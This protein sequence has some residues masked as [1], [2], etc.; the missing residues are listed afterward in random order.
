MNLCLS[1]HGNVVRFESPAGIQQI[2]GGEEGYILCDATTGTVYHDTGTVEDGFGPPT[3]IQPNGV[4]SFPFT[5]VRTTLDGQFTL[6]QTFTRA[7]PRTVGDNELRIQS[8][9]ANNT[10]TSHQLQLTRYVNADADGSPAHDIFG[11]T[12]DAVLAW[13]SASEVG[14]SG[15]G[16][17]MTSLAYKAGTRPQAAV[18]EYPGTRTACGASSLVTPRHG[19]NLVGELTHG[20]LVGPMGKGKKGSDH[21]TTFIVYS[22]F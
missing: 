19:T 8:D 6:S 10:A 21:F 1:D 20:G 2:A 15:N 14:D 4:N 9:V 17:A 3:I 22:R 5:V 18:E 13:D 11:R 12:R 16:L 7:R